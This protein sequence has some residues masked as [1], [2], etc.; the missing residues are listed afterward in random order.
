MN[1]L[2]QI[3]GKGPTPEELV[4]KWRQ[5]IRTQE[6]TLDRQ[7]RS[8]EME[9]GKVKKALKQAANK[10]D[11]RACQH[12]AKELL[13]SRK[14]KDRLHTS[15]AQ[16]NS[17][18]MQMQNQLA[19][20]KVAGSLQKSTAVIKTVNQLVKLPEISVAMQEMSAEMMKAGIMEEMIEDTLEGMDEDDI[21]EE[22]DEEVNKVLFEVTEGLL[23]QAGAV[24]A[25]IENA[26]EEE[27]ELDAM[28]ARLSALRS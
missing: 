16:L 3:F 25:P 14:H 12:L 10:G 6:R 22:A 5:S 17:I 15:K 21:E 13:H 11:K 4:R 24:G 2:Q 19:T 1:A 9:E 23:G 26:Q 18:A 27:P 28:Q 20:I 7:I 8:I